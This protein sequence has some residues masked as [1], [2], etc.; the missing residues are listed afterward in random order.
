MDYKTL[1]GEIIRV[2]FALGGFNKE[3]PTCTLYN[4]LDKELHMAVSTAGLDVVAKWD[5]EEYK[6]FADRTYKEYV[7]KAEALKNLESVMAEMEEQT[8]I[9]NE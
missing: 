7:T 2:K 8:L 1:D 6:R 4:E 3:I 5:T 9:I